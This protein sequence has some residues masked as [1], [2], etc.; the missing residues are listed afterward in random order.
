MNYLDITFPYYQNGIKTVV[1]SGEISLRQF[2]ETIKNPKEKVRKAFIDIQEAANSGNIKLKDELK[3]KNLFFTTPSVKL[4]YRNYDSIQE[5]LPL[6]VLEYDKITYPEE[7]RDYI[8]EN[9]KS[10]IFAFVSPS[11][12]GCKFIFLIEKPTSVADYKDLY[13]GIARDLDKFKGFDI[14]NQ[15]PTLPLFNS[16][17][18]NALF[19]GDAITSTVRGYKENAFDVDA[20]IDFE[21]P[22]N[23]D[24]VTEKRVVR[25]IDFLIDKIEDNAHPQILG[26][27]FLISG[28]SAANYI[29]E[30]LAFDTMNEAIERN[31]YMSK[32]VRGYLRTAKQ[33]FI[34]GLDYPAEFKN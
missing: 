13:F 15:N 7:L 18:E 33:M 22:E 2:I 29:G 20:E 5:F 32:D 34:K 3:Q 26:L 16:W 8:F 14:S 9:F 25:K 21:I 1:P 23:I 24:P 6:A 17:D 31:E 19:R 4:E 11:K 30:E 10:C 12:T 28:F 27:A